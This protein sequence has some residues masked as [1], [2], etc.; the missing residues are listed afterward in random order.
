VNGRLVYAGLA[1]AWLML[2]R[3]PALAASENALE[4]LQRAADRGAIEVTE[5]PP[6][7]DRFGEVVNRVREND[8]IYVELLAVRDLG[9][10][11]HASCREGIRAL[12]GEA[13]ED[14]AA[15]EALYRS[16]DWYEVNRAL[17][18]LRYWQAWL[19]LSLGQV[20]PDEKARVTDLSRA[21]RGFEAA[22]LRILYPGLVYGSWLGLSYV[23]RV[24]GD[25]E[26]ARRRLDLLAQALASDPENP[27]GE[28]VRDEL[29]MMDVRA[30]KLLSSGDIAVGEIFTPA[31]ARLAEEQVFALLAQHRETEVGAIEAARLLRRLIAQGY[32]DDR[33]LARMLSFQEEIVGQDL[34]V[35]SRLLE[36]EYAYAYQQYD[37]NVLKYRAFAAAGGEELPLTLHLFRYHYA[38][39]LYQIDLVREAQVV[40]D[41][42]LRTPGLS[43]E[44]QLAL[45]KLDFIVAES[46]YQD[47]AD[48][49]RAKRMQQAAHRYIE[50]APDDPDLASAWLALARIANDPAA[51]ES[52]LSRAGSDRRLRDSVRMVELD[53][54]VAEFQRANK[55]GNDTEVRSAA[56]SALAQLG[57]LKKKQREELA[58]RVLSVQLRSVLIQEQEGLLE[59]IALLQAH[60]GLT[61]SQARV[62]AWS[63]LRVLDAQSGV[64]LARFVS[65]LP[66]AGENTP[67]DHELFAFL[68]EM[69]G[70]GRLDELAEL[71]ALWLPK[72]APQPQLQRQVWLLRIDALR[73]TGEGEEALAASQALLAAH[74]DS[75]NAWRVLAEQSEA[76]GDL[77]GAERAWAHIAAAE[78]EGSPL[79]LEVS[80][81]RLRLLAQLDAVDRGCKLRGEIGIYNHLLEAQDQQALQSLAGDCQ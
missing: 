53:A 69:Q 41:G 11:L 1:L 81:Y 79:W 45:S 32:L 30:G 75:G 38:V 33:L 20:N 63:Q 27:L 16:E 47:R 64:A 59:E 40:V 36:A 44:L 34:G 42:L 35:I 15:L 7:A 31:T 57:E 18:T 28:I 43:A 14:E 80:M 51:R 62:L 24:E 52:Y 8:T 70:D 54:A 73:G 12:E 3:L 77:F 65:T 37:S 78:P 60:P 13:G 5:C 6:L 19:D 66:T 2:G 48:E 4:A 26:A 67:L 23:D 55:S 61:G 17:A 9:E 58:F 25:D 76:S 72:L 56:E 39:S 49:A 74:P 68:R 50:T 21:R 10:S 46:L 22:S 29:R 71:S